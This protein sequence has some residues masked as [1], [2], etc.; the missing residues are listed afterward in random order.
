MEH[1]IPFCGSP[2]D[3]A[4]LQRRERGWVDAQLNDDAS[5]FLPIWRGQPLIK[6]ESPALAWAKRDFF[7]DLETPDPVLL[8]LD[9]GVPHFAVDVSSVEKP[10][11]SFGLEGVASFGDLRAAV[12]T[13]PVA[14]G[15]I[16]AQ[17][18]TMV[19]WHGRHTHCAVC[20]GATRAVQGGAQRV[21][22]D[23][24]AEHFPRTDPVAIAVVVRDDQCLLGRGPGWP[25]GMFSA[26][27][28]FVEAGES[29]EEAVRREVFE[30]AGVRV[31]AVD[32][33]HYQPWPFP[34]SLM[35]GCV[36]EA[37]TTELQV[38]E[39][40]LAEA[41]WFSKQAL[42]DAIDGKPSEVGVP[43]PM[44]IAHHLIR[45]WVHT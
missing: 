34:S 39:V 12:A 44:A 8:G 13:L 23:C 43:P 25:E 36:A 37:E 9:D 35:L 5:R 28:G 15:A 7:D 45:H 2:L 19:D 22:V 29:L 27:A 40:E 10:D 42:R 33:L 38:D 17:A 18:R 24:G 3:R 11:D 41:R 20:G 26:L 32:Y 1:P 6:Q 21:C 31:G 30:E 4:A 14:D 16:A